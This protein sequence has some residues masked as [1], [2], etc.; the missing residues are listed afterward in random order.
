MNTQM[1]LAILSTSAISAIIGAV[2]AGL[3]NL[4][5]K[6]NDYVN[7]YYKAVIARRIAAYEQLEKLIGQLKACVVSEGDNRP[8]HLLFSSEKVEDWTRAFVSLGNAMDQGL[9]LSDE[10][11]DKLRDLN[12]LL[13]RFNKPAS[14]IEFGKQNYQ[15]VATWRAD[16]E[17]LLAK[18]MLRLHDVKRFLKHKNKSDPGFHPVQ[19]KT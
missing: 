4:R 9:W 17:R 7:D 5:A 3:Y 11:F 16:L 14:V 13:F 2:I 6:R 10:V 8:Y 19:L 15:T 1:L 12:Y 18:D